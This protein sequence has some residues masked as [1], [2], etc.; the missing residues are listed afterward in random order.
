MTKITL[1]AGK[2]RPEVLDRLLRHTSLAPELIVGPAVGEDAAVID[3]GDRYLVVTTD[4]ITFTTERCGW[5][6]VCINANDIAACGG[7]PRYYSA[8]IILPEGKTNLRDVENLFSEIEDACRQVGVL[9]VGGHTEVSCA[10]NTVLV[11]GQM[12]GEVA[13]EDLCR[14][15]GAQV[16]DALVLVKSAAIE[17]TAI[18]ATEK[19]REIE[20]TCGTELAERTR[21]FL[22]D[23]GIS[24]VREAALA[25]GFPVHAMHDPTEGGLVTGIREICV[26]SGCGVLVEENSVSVLPETEHLCRQF[27]LHPLGA[28][29]SGA[30]L[31]TLAPEAASHLVY[32]YAEAGIPAVVIG[33]ILRTEAGLQLRDETGNVAPLPMFEVDEITKLFS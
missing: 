8:A 7:T 29:S 26:A 18:I 3:Y 21:N 2:L 30:L 1:P 16:G 11:A 24:V 23:P 12:I 17:A 31:L 9:W 14:S 28:I 13:S 10:V 25:R 4:P 20:A 32:H 33:E 22:L 6:S 27:G 5:Y 19:A 15:S